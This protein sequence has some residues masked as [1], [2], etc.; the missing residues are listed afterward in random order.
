M[1]DAAKICRVFQGPAEYTR[2][3]AGVFSPM[4]EDKSGNT[5]PISGYLRAIREPFGKSKPVHV[6]GE[7][8]L[9]SRK[10]G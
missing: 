3:G 10:G 2:F 9:S 5:A 7:S 8:R 1:V 4:E 6:W